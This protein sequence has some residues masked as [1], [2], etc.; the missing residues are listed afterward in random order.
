MIKLSKEIE[1]QALFWFKE[2]LKF[3]TSNP[4]GME[5]AA[6]DFIAGVLAK[7]GIES[8][9]LAKDSERPNLYAEIGNRSTVP[10]ILLSSHVDVVPIE[11]E[12]HWKFPAFSATEHDGMIWGRGA[13]DVKYKT[14]FDLALLIACKEKNLGRPLKLLVLSDEEAGCDYGSKYVLKDHF[15]LVAAEYVINE[16]GGFNLRLGTRD[17]FPI[18][19]GEKGFCHLRI[20]AHGQSM[21]ASTPLPNTPIAIL[22]R[23]ITALEDYFLG[24]RISPSSKRFF[25]GVAALQPEKLSKVFLGLLDALT[26]ED[27]LALMDDALLRAQIKAML[28]NTVVPT[29]IGGGFKVNVVP[30]S[31]WVDFDCRLMP[32]IS[33]EE[34]HKTL[35]IFLEKVLGD[36]ASTLKT[37]IISFQNGYELD[38]EDALLKSIQ[39]GVEAHWKKAFKQPKALPLLLPASSDNA[40]YFEAGIKP[41]GFAPLKFPKDFP[42]FALAHA[43]NERIPVKSFLEGLQCYVAVLGS[44]L[45]V[46]K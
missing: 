2:L 17:V 35:K 46:V 5:G 11:N 45:G 15:D 41:I 18:Q 42:G 22:A 25:E 8:K 24:I 10:A 39:A 33:S 29:R 21:H 13:L 9:I 27:S 28:C 20:H 23:T 36:S 34:F 1:S 7:A 4:P 3:D 38:P 14:A 12:S 6:I 37:E 30:E 26:V 44:V 40:H 32:G 19:A 31:A 16:V 43:V